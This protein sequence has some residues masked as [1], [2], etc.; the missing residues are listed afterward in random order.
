MNL[1][2]ILL[3]GVF[4]CF[5][6]FESQALTR[7]E[8]LG[9]LTLKKESRAVVEMVQGTCWVD[10]ED[11]KEYGG[12]VLDTQ[13]VHLMGSAYLIAEGTGTPVKDAVTILTIPE[14]GS[15]RVWIRTRNWIKDCAPGRFLLYVNGT[16]LENEFGA[17]DS[18]EWVWEDGGIVCLPAGPCEL[19]L[20]DLTGY[21][22]RCDALVLT[23]DLS[24]VPPA[25]AEALCKERARLTGLSLV[26]LDHGA[27][28]VIVV[29]G[30]PSGVP[31]A[32]A[33]S[34]LGMKTALIQ[35]RPVLG[36]NASV[37]LG[38]PIQGAAMV[39]G[40]ARE[41]GICEEL[42]RLKTRYGFSQ[43][44][45]PIELALAGETNLTV[46]LNQHV[47]DATVD[48]SR[49]T[50]V[51]AV[52]TLSGLKSCFRAKMFV[53]C[54][55]DGW[56]GYYA[57]A[58]YVMGREAADEYDES[59]APAVAD[60][61]TM[62]GCL[63]GKAFNFGWKDAGEPVPYAA[64]E[65][66]PA[67]PANP[68]F[69]RKAYNMNGQW[70]LEHSNLLDD[71]WNGEEARDELIRINFGYWD[72]LK[73][74]WEKKSTAANA[75]LTMI[76]IMTARRESRRLLGDVVLN[77]ND[78]VA[79]RL[80]DDAIGHYG[81]MLDIHHPEGIYSGEKGA[82]D[83]NTH[84]PMGSIPYRSLY[85]RNIDNL[86]MGG[87]CISVSHVALGTVRVEGQ[88]AVTGQA[89]GTAAGLC[90][91]HDTTPRGIYKT[92]LDELQQTLLRYDQYVPGQKNE[93]PADAA[94]RAIVTATSSA[95][96]DKMTK[97]AHEKSPRER[98]MPMHIPHWFFFQNGEQ[99]FLGSFYLN[100]FS[101]LKEPTQLTLRLL[102]ARSMWDR[103]AVSE[104]KQ[105]GT[106]TATVQ[107]GVNGY[108]RFAFDVPVE[109][110][111][112][113]IYCEPRNAK[114]VCASPA[115]RG[116][117]GSV[118]FWKGR[119]GL[120]ESVKPRLMVYTE[121]ALMLARDYE[122]AQ[123]VNGL[124]RHVGIHA[125]QWRSDPEQPLPQSLTLSWDT[126][127]LVDTVQLTFDTDLDANPTF[128]KYVPECVSDYTVS[129]FDGKTWE[130]VVDE[131]DNFQRLRVH[132]FPQTRIEKLRLT[133]T[134]T[135]GDPSVRLYEIRA[136]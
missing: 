58:D 67:F 81:W 62:S 13:F 112:F 63:M 101:N 131:S 52:D 95:S 126:P 9:R 119:D 98:V 37:E 100:L 15:F 59:H 96:G 65:W 60:T 69:G 88:C 25:D 68:E 7:S 135:H 105:L 3:V 106:A 42:N 24:Y 83:F 49:I 53:D 66:V 6:F 72:W 123:A 4:V 89:A 130:T 136:Y 111:F 14:E 30:G 118:N 20:H 127:E 35:N 97:Q 50:G 43:W 36:G 82:Y 10:A 114:G 23:K 121:P 115:V 64:P 12:W 18:G 34:R 33:A 16:P 76:P 71:V 129:V 28:D 47:Y 133:V 41:S 21:Y 87:R 94:R 44:T 8:L 80:F 46:F 27:Y 77:Q 124:S 74:K 99:K 75:R 78:C 103:E 51:C 73:N 109:T 102:E 128:R 91:K 132:K 116:F 2:N 61:A 45:G 48:G 5:G 107:P 19:R 22:G 122:P 31:A 110:P 54:T 86:L 1:K 57:G 113:A 55:G 134:K 56:V 17:E 29:G 85:S 11:F 39:K 32:L 120:V 117:P 93:D 26:P 104:P 90:V 108:V 79:G 70:W 38:V 40:F 84:I 125:N 92:R